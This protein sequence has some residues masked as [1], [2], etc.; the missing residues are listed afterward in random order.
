MLCFRCGSPVSDGAAFCDNCGQDLSSSA[1]PDTEKFAELQKKLRQTGREWSRS[2][3]YDVG[4]VVAERYEI[5]DVVGSGALGMVFKAFDQ[6][7]EVEVALKVISSEFL[8]DDEARNHFLL[9]L[10]RARDLVHD[11]VVRCFDVDRDGNR[12]FYVMQFLKGLTLRK[13][14]DLRRSKGQRFSVEEVEPIYTQLCVA[15]NDTWEIMVHG[16]LKP[17]NIVILPDLLKL[18]DFGLPEVLPRA[19]YLAAQRVTGEACRYLAPEVL[20]KQEYDHRSDIYSVGVLVVE[21][22]T[23]QP[24]PGEPVA[25]HEHMNGLTPAVDDVLRRAVSQDPEERQ[26]SGAE[27]GQEL[28]GALEGGVV[29]VPRA[30]VTALADVD[31]AATRK[32]PKVDAD[33]EISKRPKM[34]ADAETSK[35]P[36]VDA[37]ELETTARVREPVAPEPEFS[38]PAAPPPAKERSQV[39]HQLDI[40]DIEFASQSGRAEAPV[41]PGEEEED[42]LTSSPAAALGDLDDKTARVSPEEMEEKIQEAA[43]ELV[44]VPPAAAAEE[45]PREPT[46]QIDAGMIVEG[47]LEEEPEQALLVPPG[48]INHS[49]ISGETST[50]GLLPPPE[51]VEEASEPSFRPLADGLGQKARSKGS[52]EREA[53]AREALQAFDFDATLQEAVDKAHEVPEAAED[54]ESAVPLP[55]EEPIPEDDER[56]KVVTPDIGPSARGTLEVAAAARPRLVDEEGQ[57]LVLAKEPADRVPV[58]WTLPVLIGAVVLVLVIGTA[59]LIYYI[60]KKRSDEALA[61]LERKRAVAMRLIGQPDAA[62]VEPDAAVAVAPVPVPLREDAAAPPPEPPP[63]AKVAEPKKVVPVQPAPP[64]PRPAVKVAARPKRVVD[65]PAPVAARPR[66]EPPRPRPAPPRPAPLPRVAPDTKS[67]K[68]CPGGLRFIPGRAGEEGVCIDRY[69]Y[70]GRGRV[71]ARSGLGGA[72]A[73]CKARGLRLCTAK[74]WIRACGGLFPYGR[75]YDP[76]RCNTGSRAAL[77]AGSKRG[78]RSRWGVYD[79]SGNVSEWVEEGTAMGGD[80]TSD[81]GHAGCLSRSPGGALTGFRCCSDPEWD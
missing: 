67:S 37:D 41:G 71:P 74:E 30:V 28:R 46:Q 10:Q 25:V 54:P 14:M 79:M 57:T 51:P 65:R 76:A 72:R 9:G 23:G 42:I 15:L 6:E 59:G 50:E 69:E 21:L 60:T 13:I 78:C 11:N 7:L 44:L 16:G 45:P 48:D 58:S 53:R 55:K 38:D 26:G 36:K 52:A 29:A 35:R 49:Q 39:T 73:A 77:A 80:A 27:L 81:Q 1:S 12:C 5:R 3:T 4:E 61:E 18:T 66:V 75:T 34:D 24:Y 17:D 32:R 64:A 40:D 70:P 62:P 31:E 47:S 33:A 56:P 20:A 43:E 63:A 8:P 2:A 22:L 68:K 19:A